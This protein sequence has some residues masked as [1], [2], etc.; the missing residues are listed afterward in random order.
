MPIVM[1]C[2]G[3]ITEN[4]VKIRQHRGGLI[5]SMA[6][7]VEIEGTRQSLVEFVQKLFKESC[8][9]FDDKPVEDW[10]I[11]HEAYGFDARIQWNTYVVR[12]EGYGVL[13]FTDGPTVN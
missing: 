10:Q 5:E 13:G 4:S 7:V 2:C 8:I 6:T 9:G 3:N 12:I 11:K 1:P